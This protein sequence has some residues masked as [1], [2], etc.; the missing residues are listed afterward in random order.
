MFDFLLWFYGWEDLYKSA[1]DSAF[2]VV[3]A[4][5]AWRSN[6]PKQP[7]MSS[8]LF[9]SC[10]KKSKLYKAFLKSPTAQNRVI[11]NKYR[12]KFKTLKTEAI[13]RY[14]A[15]RFNSCANDLKKLEKL[16]NN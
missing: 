7:W 11:F 10:K 9:K 6:G 15:E 13:R 2:P 8:A 14:Y 5:F 12:N 4:K 3:T 1:Y 16:S